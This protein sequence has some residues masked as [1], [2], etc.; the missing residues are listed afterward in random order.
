MGNQH[1]AGRSGIR[2]MSQYMSKRF[3]PPKD[4]G[5][6]AK[7][8]KMPRLETDGNGQHVLAHK[9]PLWSNLDLRSR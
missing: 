5:Y 9:K 2:K 4:V 7:T 3:V 6:W 1:W 8:F